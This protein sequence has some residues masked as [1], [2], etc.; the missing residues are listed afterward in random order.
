L[1]CAFALSA[2][3]VVSLVEEASAFGSAGLVVAG[4][5]GLFT[6][7]GSAQSGA[8]AMIVGVVS[9]AFAKATAPTP[10]L[11]SLAA[12]AVA[13]LALA[14]RR[15]GLSGPILREDGASTAAL[16]NRGDAG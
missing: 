13:Y 12:S 1:A 4:A 5:F 10:Y 3:S 11:I 9:Y 15:E 8:A 7:F 14:R 16:S 2:E 6:R